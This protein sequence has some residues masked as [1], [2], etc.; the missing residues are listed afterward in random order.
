MAVI[1][2]N[3]LVGGTRCR[4]RATT[5]RIK[6]ALSIVGKLSHRP[7]ARVATRRVAFRE[8]FPMALDLFELTAM[9]TGIGKELVRDWR[10]LQARIERGR[11]SGEIPTLPPP[12]PRK[13]RRGGRRKPKN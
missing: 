11:A 5:D 12:P 13:R 10:A 4:P 7:D 6:Q 3:E 8:A 9:A 2:A 1:R